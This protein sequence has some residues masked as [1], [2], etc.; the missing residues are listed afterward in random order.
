MKKVLVNILGDYILAAV[1]AFLGLILIVLGA[2]FWH[3][4]IIA[5]GVL[6]LIA[7]FLSNLWP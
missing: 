4:L 1:I 3:P 2:A 6:I 7:L 5:G